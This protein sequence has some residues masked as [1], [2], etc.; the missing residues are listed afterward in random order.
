MDVR[1]GRP[2]RRTRPVRQ[3]R[4]PPADGTLAGEPSPPS[5]AR[6]APPPC[7][8]PRVPSS[9]PAWPPW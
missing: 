4:R 7:R 1:R 5:P 9:R 2:G 8:R 3:G 6:A